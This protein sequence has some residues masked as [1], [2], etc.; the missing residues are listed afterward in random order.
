MQ[1]GNK[2]KPIQ[3]KMTLE[4]VLYF[5]KHKGLTIKLLIESDLNYLEWATSSGAIELDNNAYA[6]FQDELVKKEEEKFG[7]NKE[8]YDR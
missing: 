2:S 1:F 5:G 6:H 8:M 4:S 3:E 7:F